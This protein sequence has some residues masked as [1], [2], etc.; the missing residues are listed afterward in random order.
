MKRLIWFAPFV[1]ALALLAGCNKEIQVAKATFE[2]TVTA[3]EGIDARAEA[4]CSMEYLT[5]GVPQDVMDGV[6]AWIVEN[7]ILFDESNGSTDVP[8]AVKTWVEETVNGCGF[9]AEE[10]T[11]E[12]AWAY[13]WTFEREG[14]FTTASKSRHLQ[15][16][17]GTYNDYTGGSHGQF[18]IGCDVFDLTTG[19]VLTEEDL[20]IDDFFSPLCDLLEEAVE[21]NV[22]GEDKDLLFGTPEPNGNFSVSEDGIT[23]VYNPYEIAAYASGVIELPVSWETLKPLLQ[24]RWR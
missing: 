9:E 3:G 14:A 5:G 20:F 21:A 6:N 23:W 16:Y 22:P 24:P 2:D 10:I 18:G 11:E 12:N 1:A 15:T 17:T 8:A 7:H 13:H 4:S 19:S